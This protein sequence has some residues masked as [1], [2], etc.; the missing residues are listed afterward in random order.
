ME[1][2]KVFLLKYEDIQQ[3]NWKIK[4]ERKKKETAEILKVFH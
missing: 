3:E 1:K 2:I 4:K